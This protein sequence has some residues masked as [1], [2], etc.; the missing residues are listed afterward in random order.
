MSISIRTCATTTPPPYW[1][2]ITCTASPAAS[3][4]PWSGSPG[5]WRG[6]TA[7]SAR[8]T[9]PTPT[10]ASIAW[11]KTAPS[12]LSSPRR[13][14]TRRNRGSKSRADPTPRGRRRWS[15]TAASTC[16]SRT[17]STATTS[18]AETAETDDTPDST[19]LRRLRLPAGGQRPRGARLAHVGRH[20]G[21]QHGLFHELRPCHV[22]R[23]DDEV[24]EVGGET[25]VADLWQPRGGGRTGLRRHQ[26]RTGAQP[27][28]SRRPQ[29]ADV[30]PRIR[31]RVP[32]A[33]RQSETGVRRGSGLARHRRLLLASGGSPPPVLRVE[34]LRTRLPGHAR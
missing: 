22:G 5:K 18:N 31:R 14:P 13:K 6:A 17:T 32:V 8:A 23:Q 1:W 26:Q 3:S 2:A 12:G 10:S 28:R 11:A 34:P 33:A 9:A 25:G 19:L 29:R 24:R 30:L 27:H 4:P 15:P 16:A 20:C 21:P 7:A